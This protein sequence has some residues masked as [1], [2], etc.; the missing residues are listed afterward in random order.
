MHLKYSVIYGGSHVYLVG[1][2][3][4]LV[5]SRTTLVYEYM[6]VLDRG[7]LANVIISIICKRELYKFFILLKLRLAI[8]INN[9]FTEKVYRGITYSRNTS[10]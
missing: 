10:H 1:N 3:I 9:S 4:F 8:F 7:S 6:S 5:Q 2:L